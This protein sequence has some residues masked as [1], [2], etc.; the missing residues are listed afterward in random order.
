MRSKSLCIVRLRVSIILPLYFSTFSA[1]TNRHPFHIPISLFLSLNF[2]RP[3]NGHPEFLQSL[4]SP[5][6]SLPFTSHPQFHL[7]SHFPN[8]LPS[9]SPPRPNHLS[10][11]PPPHPQNLPRIRLIRRNNPPRRPWQWRWRTWAWRWR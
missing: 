8:P 4:H 2:S 3:K 9:L 5:A 6:L 1:T 10:P 11:S 7:H